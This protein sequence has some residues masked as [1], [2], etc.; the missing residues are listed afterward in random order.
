VS[1]LL[2]NTNMAVSQ[3]INAASFAAYQLMLKD[4]LPLLNL[5]PQL[6]QLPIKMLSPVYGDLDPVFTNFVAPGIMIA[7]IY[8][9]SIALTALS[10]VVDRK[11]GLLSRIWA[12]GVRPAEVILAHSTTQIFIILGQIAA[13][14]IFTFLVF[15]V[16]LVGNAA[17]MLLLLVFAGITGM[18]FGLVI[19]TRVQTEAAAIQAALGSF[20]P[21]LLLSGIIWPLEAMPSWLLGIAMI[22]PT[23][24]AATA[25]R[26]ILLRGWSMYNLQVWPGFVAAVLWTLFY[27]FVATRFI[28][29]TE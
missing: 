22:L 5:P 4:A 18:A 23:T 21:I 27:L 9:Q 24:H 16:P 2:D 17:L 12:A 26:C 25:M 6:A 28:R 14:C 11:E 8:L 19:S 20:F 7:L 15:N 13:L 3:A 1:L 10:F 29:R